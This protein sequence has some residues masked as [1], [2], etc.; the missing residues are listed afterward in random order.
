[1]SILYFLITF[2]LVVN[3]HELGHFF[4]AKL[5]GVHVQEYGFGWPPRLLS[6]KVK[7]TIY[8]LNLLL[9]GGFVKLFGKDAEEKEAL[10]SSKSFQKKSYLGKISIMLGGIIFN[11]ILAYIIFFILFITGFPKS[12]E[13]RES[14]VYVHNITEKSVAD[15]A[16]MA[17]GDQIISIQGEEVNDYTKIAEIVNKFS[18]QQ[19]IITI[20]RGEELKTLTVTPDPLLGILVNPIPIVKVGADK[21]ALLAAKEVGNTLKEVVVVFYRLI[22]GKGEGIEVS[23]PVGIARIS[24]HTA[25]MGAS[26]FWQF[27]ASLSL[28]LAVIN[29]IPFPALDGGWVLLTTIESFRRRLINQKVVYIINTVGFAIIIGLLIL[30]TVRDLIK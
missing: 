26:Y 8:S 15:K 2:I 5:F 20:E 9:A 22:S 29:F 12:S 17:V 30:V 4:F 11:I 16:G 7:G 21:A 28:N 1:M 25:R 27:I 14:E 13:Y 6:K 3:I 10:T 23:G 18:G 19:I 24:Q